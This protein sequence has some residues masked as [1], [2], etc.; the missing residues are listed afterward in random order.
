MRLAPLVAVLVTASSLFAGCLD[1]KGEP[2][3]S[4]D[5]DAAYDFV[6]GL[7][8]NSEGHPR[9]RVPGT[10]GHAEAAQWLWDVMQVPGWTTAWQNFTGADYIPLDKG[11]VEGYYAGGHCSSDERARLASLSFHNLWAVHDGPGDPLVLL[12]AHWESKRFANQDAN[13]ALREA[14]VLG[15]NDGA[16]GVGVLLQFMR[17]IAQNAVV[18]PFDVG[19]VFFDGEDGFEDCHPLAGSIYFVDRLQSGQ[20]DRFILLDMVGSPDARF[21]HE[22][23]SSNCDPAL[24]QLFHDEAS[25]VG[26]AANFPGTRRSVLDDHIPFLAAGIPSADVIDYGRSGTGFPP[27]WHTTQDT[28]EHIDAGMLGRVGDLILRVLQAPAFTQQ[29][30]GSC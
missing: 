27:Q 5:G 7:V 2:A 29:W 14:P 25:S 30:P 1:S 15:A 3:Q 6:A 19:V 16:S 13:P 23:N 18:L 28:L 21:V 24:M 11:D 17:H 8:T 20:V 9:Y 4:F 22:A 10:D 12:G 26:L